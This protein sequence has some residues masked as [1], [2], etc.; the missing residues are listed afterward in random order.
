[1]LQSQQQPAAAMQPKPCQH[2]AAAPLPSSTGGG[3]H[4]PVDAGPIAA[5]LAPRRRCACQLQAS[6][7]AAQSSDVFA[8]AGTTGERTDGT[9]LCMLDSGPSTRH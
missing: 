8:R 7:G 5:V 6:Q 4:T 1:M 2:E 9:G 3:V